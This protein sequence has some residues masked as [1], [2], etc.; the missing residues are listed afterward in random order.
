MTRFRPCI[1]LHEGQVKQ[2]VGSSL[3]DAGPGLMT[4]FVAEHD[5]A[6]FATRY[7]ADNLLGGHV[8]KLGPGNDAAARQALTAWPGGLQIG[9]GI[10]IDNAIGW[11]DAG[12]SQVIV[13]S[14]CFTDGELDW[15]RVAAL[16]KQVGRERLV[17]DLSCR[18]VGNGWQ[19]ATDRWQTITQSTLAAELLERLAQYASEFLIQAADVEGRRAG[20]DEGLIQSLAH[21][22]PIPCTYA[23]GARSLN[24]LELCRSL[25]DGRIDLTIG[26]ALDIFGGDCSYEACCA[27]NHAQP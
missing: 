15:Q 12:A 25:S 26:S 17:L 24:D 1:D 18:H 6:D 9:G 22:S 8:I 20:M 14:W 27:W 7:R 10:T 11:L 3:R 13:T 5:A 4:N 21:W 19:I 23:G 2:I 16:S